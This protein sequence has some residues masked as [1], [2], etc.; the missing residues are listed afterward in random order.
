LN[1]VFSVLKK[2][3]NMMQSRQNVIE[4]QSAYIEEKE[5]MFGQ[6]NTLQETVSEQKEVIATQSSKISELEK[7]ITSNEELKVAY[8]KISMN[9]VEKNNCDIPAWV[10]SIT[11][12]LTSQKK[13]IDHLTSSMQHNDKLESSCEGLNESFSNLVWETNENSSLISHYQALLQKQSETITMFRGILTGIRY[14]EENGLTVSGS[15]CECLPLPPANSSLELAIVKF[16][17]H[18]TDDSNV[19][20]HVSCA[21]GKCETDAWPDCSTMKNKEEMEKD[22]NSEWLYSDCSELTVAYLNMTIDCGNMGHK[23]ARLDEYT[24]QGVIRQEYSVPCLDCNWEMFEWPLTLVS[25]QEV[26]AD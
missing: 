21:D 25:P 15:P 3:E 4:A 20:Y 24:D 17:C 14:Q 13:S 11:E 18:E 16:S 10:A 8:E 12:G 6:C 26:L 9:F 1:F 2:G 23:T 19:S 5:A 7:T 22:E